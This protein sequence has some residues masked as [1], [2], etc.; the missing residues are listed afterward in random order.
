[1]HVHESPGECT[2]K[3]R[4][5]GARIEPA[6]GRSE[7]MDGKDG[8]EIPEGGIPEATPSAVAPGVA[9]GAGNELAVGPPGA[10]A[11]GT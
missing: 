5:D 8:P 2:Y 10:D 7:S 11:E 9:P 6:D 1:M 4:M 3:T